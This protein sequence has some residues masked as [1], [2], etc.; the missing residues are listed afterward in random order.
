M[1]LGLAKS[2]VFEACESCFYEDIEVQSP[3][4]EQTHTSSLQKESGQASAAD[5]KKTVSGGFRESK[6]GAKQEEVKKAEK[7]EFFNKTKTNSGLDAAV[8]KGT[9]SGMNCYI[10][11]YFAE[12][13]L[14][15]GRYIFYAEHSNKSLFI[16]DFDKVKNF[17]IE[18]YGKPDIDNIDWKNNLFKDDPAEWGLAISMGHLVY[19]A[20]WE[21][22]DALIRLLLS[23]DNYDITFALDYL[24]SSAAHEE[25]R[26]KAEEKAKKGI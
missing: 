12:N 8:Y 6:W 9:A 26:N 10:G 16:D 17:L 22:S 5:P 2:K 7:A 11:Y 15:E 21:L 24:S 20:S 14:V 3:T 19:F 1:S 13:V 4:L 18:K 23:G 25:L